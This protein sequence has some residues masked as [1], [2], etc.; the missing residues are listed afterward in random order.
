MQDRFIDQDRTNRIVYKCDVIIN[1]KS[2]Q[3]VKL[4]F[5]LCTLYH[6]YDIISYPNKSQK[7]GGCFNIGNYANHDAKILFLY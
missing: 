2:C 7:C 5:V 3:S 6:H 4:F 1:Q